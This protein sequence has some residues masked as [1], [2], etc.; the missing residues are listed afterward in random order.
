MAGA[1]RPAVHILESSALSGARKDMCIHHKG[2]IYRLKITRQGTL[3]L[4]KQRCRR[5][6]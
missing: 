1:G 3:I 5:L 4:N 6:P 2:A